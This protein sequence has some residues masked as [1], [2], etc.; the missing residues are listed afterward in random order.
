VRKAAANFGD[1]I[2][3]EEFYGMSTLRKHDNF[4]DINECLCRQSFSFLVVLGWPRIFL[5][6]NTTCF[7]IQLISWVLCYLCHHYHPSC[8]FV[9]IWSPSHLIYSF[10]RHPNENHEYILP[11]LKTFKAKL[12]LP[13]Q[14]QIQRLPCFAR[15]M[16]LLQQPPSRCLFQRLSH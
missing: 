11:T 16:F 2:R 14:R 7:I 13:S 8:R 10:K 12:S 3:M 1:R 6:S 5:A 9:S 15:Q 4:R